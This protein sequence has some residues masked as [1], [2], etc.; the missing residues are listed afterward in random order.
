MHFPRQTFANKG[1]KLQGDYQLRSALAAKHISL[2]AY[3]FQWPTI[4]IWQCPSHNGTLI[5]LISD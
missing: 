5:T 3:N 1:F 2:Q 4:Q